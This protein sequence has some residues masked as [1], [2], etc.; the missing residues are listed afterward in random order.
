M[1]ITAKQFF[2]KEVSAELCQDLTAADLDAVQTALNN[3]LAKFEV[4]TTEEGRRDAE[5]GDMLEAFLDAKRIEGRS[6]KTLML[7]RYQ[8][9]RLLDAVDVPIRQIT[10]FHLRR[11]LT[12]RK[13]AGL[14]D[15][16]LSGMRD[17]YC[18][19]FGWL[20]KEGLLPAN[21]AA[22]LAPIKV[23]KVVRLPFNDVELAKLRE[24]C[25]GA[26]DRAIL[27]F[28]SSTGCR[29]SEMCG[30]DRADVDLAKGE[31]IVM[32]KGAKERVVFLD[33][34]T[35]MLLERYLRTR[36]DDFPALFVGRGSERLQPS[37]V[38]R[39]LHEAAARAGVQD[40]H[41][42]RFRRTLAT[43]LIGHGMPIQEVATVLGHERIDTTMTYVYQRKEDIH[44][45]FKKYA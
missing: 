13:N 40:V 15:C 10:V 17:V 1:S 31:A 30:L 14:S 3:V 43:N 32:G 27:A 36:A 22:N 6:D 34:V 9:T 11:F 12:E 16:T 28:L 8:I 7:Y 2:I 39:M 4:E 41:P 38:R 24:A 5:T 18:S 21:P 35:V 25:A 23:A 19:F 45:N 44:N 37:G 33:D 20:Y 42:H 26:R 29:V